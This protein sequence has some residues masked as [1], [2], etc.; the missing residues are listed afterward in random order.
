MALVNVHPDYVQFDGDPAAPGTF[1]VEI[2]ARLLK[3]ARDRY[4]GTFWHALPK[5]VASFGQ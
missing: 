1:S 3:Y 2:Y 5:E 4:V